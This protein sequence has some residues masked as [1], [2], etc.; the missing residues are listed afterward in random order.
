MHCLPQILRVVVAICWPVS[1]VQ[2]LSLSEHIVQQWG[3]GTWAWTPY[4]GLGGTFADLLWHR[5]WVLIVQRFG[6]KVLRTYCESRQKCQT[7]NWTAAYLK[8]EWR[9][10]DLQLCTF[11][12]LYLSISL[13]TWILIVMNYCG[14][15]SVMWKSFMGRVRAV[16][17]TIVSLAWPTCHCFFGGSASTASHFPQADFLC[18]AQS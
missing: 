4:F 7:E 18:F 9:S 15:P 5:Y 12:L 6:A 13:W 16:G 10:Q 14:G 2:D 3:Q 17:G 8:N 1:L 11:L